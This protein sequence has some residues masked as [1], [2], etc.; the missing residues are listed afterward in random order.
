MGLRDLLTGLEESGLERTIVDARPMPDGR[1]LAGGRELLDLSSNDYLGLAGRPDLAAILGSAAQEWGVGAGA[2]RLL[3]GSRSPLS[4]L[5]EAFA[6]GTGF[7]SALLFNSGYHANAG[8]LAALTTPDSLIFSDQH[9]HASIIDGCRLSPAQVRIYPHGDPGTLEEML[10]SARSAGHLR[11]SGPHFLVTEGV[12]SMDG[13]HPD[14]ALLVQLKDEYGLLLYVDDAHGF[15][16]LG[17]GGNGAFAQVLERVDLFVATFG[18]ALGVA[19]AAVA[20]GTDV[21]RLLRS[22]ARS[23]IFTTAMPPALAVAARHSLALVTGEAGREARSRLGENCRRFQTGLRQAGVAVPSN[24]HHIVPIYLH[25]ENRAAEASRRL[26][27]AGIF[28][29]AV[30]FPTVPLGAARLRCS[31]SASHTLEALERAADIIADIYNGE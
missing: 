8:I 14:P 7:E 26:L 16:V 24:C 13:D 4:R 25:D 3:S 17:Q 22:R 28:C 18:K 2:A 19:G 27:E 12:F 29:R 20:A 11:S 23:F 31:L 6:A 1:I 9:N 10:R 21:V 15:G 30:R 5:E